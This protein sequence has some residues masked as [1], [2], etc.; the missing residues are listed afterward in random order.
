MSRGSTLSLSARNILIGNVSALGL[1]KK[2]ASMN[3]S[4][5]VIKANIAAAAMLLLIRG[6]VMRLV[7]VIPEAPSVRAAS[8]R[9]RGT[10]INPAE[11]T[12][13]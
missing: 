6:K 3:S 12:N 11:T 2:K 9:E 7:V 10:A 13:A 1:A 4:N 5:D 8:S